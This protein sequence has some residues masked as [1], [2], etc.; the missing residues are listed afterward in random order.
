MPGQ[1][2]CGHCRAVLTS[3][4]LPLPDPALLREEDGRPHVPAGYYACATGRYDYWARAIGT[5]NYLL[6][7][8]DLRKVLPHPDA[9]RPAA[10]GLLRPGGRR[11]EESAVR[12]LRR[13][14]RN[15]AR[16]L[17]HGA[18]RRAGPGRC[19]ADYYRSARAVGLSAYPA[20]SRQYSPISGCCRPLSCRPTS[21]STPVN[22]MTMKR[23]FS[24]TSPIRCCC[25]ML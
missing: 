2:E 23:I 10:A 4:L 14:S 19:G 1:F 13:G 9:R 20:G 16:G 3:P 21:I 22:R 6:N 17:P 18:L 8:S 24:L 7:L 15:Q 5:G 12:R 25:G 11:K